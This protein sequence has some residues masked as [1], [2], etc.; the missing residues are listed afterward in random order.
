MQDK[1]GKEKEK[2][3]KE[4]FH[5]SSLLLPQEG[6]F[7]SFSPLARDSTHTNLPPGNKL[8][9]RELLRFFFLET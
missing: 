2:G 1:S 6:V 4:N 7:V 3:A 8:G 5:F 9:E